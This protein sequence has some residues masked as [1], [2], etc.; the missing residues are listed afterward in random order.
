V[1]YSAKAQRHG[2]IPGSGLRKEAFNLS[3]QGVANSRPQKSRWRQWRSDP[4]F[5]W[6]PLALKADTVR[7]L[8]IVI[9]VAVLAI[10]GIAAAIASLVADPPSW[11]EVAGVMGLLAAATAAEAFPLPIEGVNVG[12]G[13][14]SLAIVS[15]VGTGVIYGWEAAGLVGFL[16][17]A[18]VEAGR[19]RPPTRV[20]FNTGV[21][22]CAAILAGLAAAPF[23]DDHLGAIIAASCLSA[24]AFYIVD[25]LLLSAVIARTRRLSWR[26]LLLRYLY[27]TTLPFLVM[28]SL[29]IT[30]VVLWDRSP[31]ISII[32]LGP[33]I[34]VALHERWLH[35][36]LEQLREFDR[37]KDEFIAVISHEL[38]TPLTSVYGAALT[39]QKRD[40][41]NKMRDTLL[42]IVSDEAG[43]LARL[44]DRALSAS[45]LDANREIF[46]I[47]ALDG[48]E[49]ARSIVD[50]ARHRLP[51]GLTLELIVE[52]GLSRVLADPDKLRQILVNLTENAIKY[53]PDGG[54]VEVRVANAGDRVRF[55]VID[56]GIGIAP[57]QQEH[58]FER[59]HRLDPNM[60]RG[61]GGLG[62]G[63]Y[64]SHELVKRMDGS[65][66]VTSR[67]GAG[68]T[69][70]FEL[71]VAAGAA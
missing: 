61:V 62:L 67:E 9:P 10:V 49:I 46:E 53:S 36:A 6:S 13:T 8:P 41:D 44:L 28:T 31:W 64:I 43:R 17:M 56:E 7:S 18:I 38:R 24:A 25:M 30:L 51:P 19:R 12:A 66:W 29:I 15:I 20:V 69:F 16:T 59:F 42:D 40:V 54:R 5:R 47:V 60:T 50:A 65:I 32:V 14:T 45:R 48:G 22:V 11:G 71:P 27:S 63:L 57:E 3:S 2:H 37:L 1:S 21:Y 26:D 52:P 58:I 35:R 55:S 39:L 68:S 4:P 33:M 70:T 34:T 23:A